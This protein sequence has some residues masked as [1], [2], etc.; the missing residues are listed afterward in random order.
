MA[1]VEGRPGADL[2]PYDF[3]S[4]KRKLQYVHGNDIT[5]KDVLSAALY[6]QVFKDYIDFKDVYSTV[7]NLPT[8]AYFS[9]LKV[10]EEIKVSLRKGKELQL[11]LVATTE[12]DEDGNKQV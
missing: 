5:D 12:T 4:E 7:Q 1:P 6:P 2:E 3:D 11:K 8:Y 9:P 10:G